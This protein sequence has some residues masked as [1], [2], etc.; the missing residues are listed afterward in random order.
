MA[1]PYFDSAIVAAFLPPELLPPGIFIIAP[2]ER[3]LPSTSIMKAPSIEANS[4]RSAR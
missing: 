4:A 1:V 3:I 2:T